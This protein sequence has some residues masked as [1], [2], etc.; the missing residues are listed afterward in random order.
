MI[1]YPNGLG[2]DVPGDLFTTATNRTEKTVEVVGWYREA[3]VH[4][5][6][7]FDWS[8]SATAPCAGGQ[9][10]PS[11]IWTRPFNDNVCQI[12]Q[13]A[14]GAGAIHDTMYYANAT[15]PRASGWENRVSFWNYCTNQWDVVYT[16]VFA[17]P[18]K[19]CSVTDCGW[20][21][22]IVENNSPLEDQPFPQLGFINTRLVHNGVTSVLPPTETDFNGPPSTW[23]LCSLT[24][25]TS[26]STSQI[27][28]GADTAAW[29]ASLTINSN[30]DTGY[31]AQVAVHNGGT[32]TLST[33]SVSLA[34]NQSTL[35]S[36]HSANFQAKS[37]GQYQVTPLTWN[38]R[39]APGATVSFGFCANKSGANYTPRVTTP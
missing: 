7:I 37:P 14:D 33:W 8:C 13:M 9:T 27:P 11:W 29:T 28:C 5:I 23:K 26:W 17:G 16:H 2:F 19:D 32:T 38:S 15:V 6:G 10:T 4:H 1:I 24:P 12:T 36:S 31:C 21:G 25:N 22:P 20:W 34:M 30:W 35:S 39:L 18:Q 3:S